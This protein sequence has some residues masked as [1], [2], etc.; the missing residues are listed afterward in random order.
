MPGL[1]CLPPPE[2]DRLGLAVFDDG[3]VLEC[4]V[5]SGAPAACWALRTF[6]VRVHAGPLSRLLRWL[7]QRAAP[8][9]LRTARLAQLGRLS[10]AALSAGASGQ[11]M[12]LGFI[13]KIWLPGARLRLPAASE[14]AAEAERAA[15]E[16]CV[17]WMLEALPGPAGGGL[18]R[19]TM[20]LRHPRRP[21]AL[22]A[23]VAYWRAA[24]RV[25]VWA[26]RQ[27]LRRIARHAANAPRDPR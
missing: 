26:R 17:V 3:D 13:G 27:L 4:P 11:P 9:P 6:D 8:T 20:R 23:C 14:F 16:A 21:P 19:L 22:W 2:R 1:P 25:S 10:D 7:P 12:L 18:L 24:R 5:E 15:H